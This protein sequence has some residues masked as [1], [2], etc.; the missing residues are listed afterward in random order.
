MARAPLN[1][2]LLLLFTFGAEKDRLGATGGF[3]RSAGFWTGL[4]AGLAYVVGTVGQATGLGAAGFA[5]CLGFSFGLSGA[6]STVS[7][8]PTL[9]SDFEAS[10]IALLDLKFANR[11]FFSSTMDW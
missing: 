11:C 5:A 7:N 9:T 8:P 3:G 6:R 2:E 10:I 1:L 4:G